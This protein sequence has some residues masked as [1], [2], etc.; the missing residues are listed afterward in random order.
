MLA[1]F[2]FVKEKK[3]EF[4]EGA[5]QETESEMVA[6]DDNE[7]TSGKDDNKKNQEKQEE[8]EDTNEEKDQQPHNMEE[9]DEVT[10]LFYYKPVDFCKK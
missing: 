10:L 4:G 9:L 2:M 7:D 6:K 1:N 8:Q 3:E 5:G